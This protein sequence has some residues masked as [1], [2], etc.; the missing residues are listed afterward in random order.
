MLAISKAI[1]GQSKDLHVAYKKLPENQ[2]RK[3]LFPSHVGKYF[4]KILQIQPPES[5]ENLGMINTQKI[6][7]LSS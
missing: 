1:V 5:A 2:G 7:Y 4:Y 6:P 3:T